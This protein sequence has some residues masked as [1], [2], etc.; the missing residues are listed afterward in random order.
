MPPGVLVDGQYGNQVARAAK[1]KGSSSR[2]RSR[3]AARTEFDFEYGERFGEAIE[4]YDP[5]FSKV[6]VRYNTEG[7]SDMNAR[8]AERLKRL[9][10][11]LHEH[12]RRFLFELLVPAET[13]SARG[14]RGRRGPLRHRDPPGADDGRDPG[15]PGR[16]H[17]AGHLEDR[18]HRRS[19]DV[20]EIAELVRRDGRDQVSCIVLGRGASDDK[21]DER[22]ARARAPPGYVGFAIGRSIF[23]GAVKALAAGS[24]DRAEGVAQGGREVPSFHRRVRARVVPSEPESAIRPPRTLRKSGMAVPLPLR[25]LDASLISGTSSGRRRQPRPSASCERSVALPQQA[26]G[27]GA[28][29]PRRRLEALLAVLPSA[30]VWG[31]WSRPRHG[32]ERGSRAADRTARRRRR[33]AFARNRRRRSVRGADGARRRRPRGER[34]RSRRP[35]SGPAGSSARTGLRRSRARR[36]GRHGRGG[37]PH[38]LSEDAGHLRVAYEASSW[39]VSARRSSWSTS[40]ARDHGTNRA[41]EEI[42]GRTTAEAIVRPVHD[43]S[44]PSCRAKTTRGRCAASSAARSPARWCSG[45]RTVACS[46]S[47]SA[48]R[49]SVGTTAGRGGCHGEPRRDRQPPG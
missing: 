46:G 47:R 31:R 6:L 7:D 11:W 43:V 35:S 33:S 4:D 29:V 22:C 5:T 20:Q 26:P 28:Q 25:G 16:R 2:C 45:R 32:L 30:A 12:D 17:R 3:R 1:R 27:P 40:S 36:L 8:Q 18:G 19:G 13:H 23:G 41:A 15:A 34:A 42:Y 14:G 21:V 49:P 10:D 48:S 39:R 37:R 38:D 24:G 44:P 9:S